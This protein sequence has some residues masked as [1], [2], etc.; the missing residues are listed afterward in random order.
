[1]H[2]WF[3][4]V[5]TRYVCSWKHTYGFCFIHLAFNYA[6]IANPALRSIRASFQGYYNLDFFLSQLLHPLPSMQRF[7]EDLLSWET[8]LQKAFSWEP[9]ITH[10]CLIKINIFCPPTAAYPWNS[11]P[12]LPTFEGL[13]KEIMWQIELP[14]LYIYLYQDRKF[15]SSYC[16]C[17]LEI[18]LLH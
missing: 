12:W 7:S 5:F 14:F 9:Y 8:S 15:I 6:P 4:G 11:M 2:W 18:R 3:I 1:M 17:G 10:P 13:Q 16:R